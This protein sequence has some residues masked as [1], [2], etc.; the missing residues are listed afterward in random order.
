MELQSADPLSKDDVYQLAVPEGA[1]VQRGPLR[2]DARPFEDYTAF[3]GG[4][5]EVSAAT[6]EVAP[7]VVG[8][9]HS[10]GIGTT[11]GPRILPPSPADAAA[12]VEPSVPGEP[13]PVLKASATPKG[14]SKGAKLRPPKTAAEG[15]AALPDAGLERLAGG[16]CGDPLGPGRRHVRAGGHAQ[17]DH[18]ARLGAWR[19]TGR[20]SRRR[21]RSTPTRTTSRATRPLGTSTPTTRA[22]RR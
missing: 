6:M 4:G 5:Q 22:S 19:R 21:C 9:E 11:P 16:P 17:E 15:P 18:P 7:M 12:P 10:N 1:V 2:R 13:S 20:A 3:G 14:A 8:L